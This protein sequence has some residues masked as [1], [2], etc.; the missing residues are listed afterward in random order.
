MWPSVCTDIEI[1]AWLTGKGK[2]IVQEVKSGR[3]GII[4]LFHSSPLTQLHRKYICIRE[5]QK[6]D[7]LANEHPSHFSEVTT[8]GVGRVAQSV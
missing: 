6:K 1:Y 3:M 5:V 8:A 4:Q 7:F 2:K